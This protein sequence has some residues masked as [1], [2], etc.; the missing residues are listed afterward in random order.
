MNYILGNDV[1]AAHG[2]R[3]MPVWGLLFRSLEPYDNGIP[4]LRAKNLADYVKSLQT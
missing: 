2:S 1:I 4:A 3:D